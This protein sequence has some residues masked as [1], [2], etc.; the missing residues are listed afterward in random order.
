MFVKM[1]VRKA[2]MIVSGGKLVL[3][4]PLAYDQMTV[5]LPC[6]EEFYQASRHYLEQI[7]SAWALKRKI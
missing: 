1:C 3:K 5:S 6:P 7:S 4:R 2:L